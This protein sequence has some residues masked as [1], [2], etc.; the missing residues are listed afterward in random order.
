MSL[1]DSMAHSK[2]QTGDQK[3]DLITTNDRTLWEKFV[4]CS[5]NRR[6][7]FE[8]KVRFFAVV[9]EKRFNAEQNIANEKPDI[10]WS[11]WE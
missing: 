8:T 1:L 11:K 6:F 10:D 9:D 2:S 5:K 3:T 7:C 4:R